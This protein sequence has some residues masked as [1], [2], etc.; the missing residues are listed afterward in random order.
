MYFGNSST[1]VANTTATHV[2]LDGTTAV[3][4]GFSI[5]SNN[6]VVPLT[7]IYQCAF[8]IYYSSAGS[9]LVQ[10]IV[11]HNGVQVLAGSSTSSGL[12]APEAAGAGLVS[13]AA[14][15]TLALYAYQTSGSGLTTSSGAAQLTYL[16]VNFLGSA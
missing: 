14:N 16:H 4:Y 9:G 13:C 10:A 5:S 1:S 3:G 6:I 7:G 11:Y 8:S 12:T 15:D 2:T